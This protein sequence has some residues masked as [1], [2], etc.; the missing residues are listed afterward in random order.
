MKLYKNEQ[1]EKLYP[2]C[3]WERNQ[4]KI[5]NAVDRANIRMWEESEV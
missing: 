1:G 2:I 5:Y 4:H 3:R